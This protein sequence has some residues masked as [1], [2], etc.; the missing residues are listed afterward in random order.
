[1]DRVGSPGVGG[2]P[3]VKEVDVEVLQANFELVQHVE[4]GHLA[5]EELRAGNSFKRCA[6]VAGPYGFV[7]SDFETDRLI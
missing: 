4:T 6:I 1:M 3:V 2:E 5:L 7:S